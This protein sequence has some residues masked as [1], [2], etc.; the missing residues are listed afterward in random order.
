[1]TVKQVMCYPDFYVAAVPV[2]E[3]V[4]AS[5]VTDAEI[6]AMKEVPMWFVHCKG[7]FVVDPEKSVLSL[8][9]ML[10]KVGAREV[11]FTYPDRIV[12]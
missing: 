3:A 5:L 8:Y 12:D 2:C 6:E 10:K 7:D 1:M 11:H 9:R 4:M